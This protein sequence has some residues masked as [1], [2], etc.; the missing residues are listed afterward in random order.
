MWVTRKADAALRAL[1]GL[2]DR[3]ERKAIPLPV[4]ARQANISIPFLQQVL[5]DLRKAGLVK[6]ERGRIGGYVLARSGKNIT[7]GDVLRAIQGTVAPSQ[8]STESA[9]P[10]C[11]RG[12]CSIRPVW[13]AVR[14]AT[15]RVVD[16]ISVEELHRRERRRGG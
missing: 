2:S 15:E 16:N 4:L 8:C 14:K 1:M 13:M 3:N 11:G 10:L 9:K 6:G 12:Y 7:V 5:F